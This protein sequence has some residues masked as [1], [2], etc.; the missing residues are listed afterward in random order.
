MRQE[1]LELLKQK[2][3]YF[4]NEPIYDMGGG[5]WQNYN[6]D[7]VFGG[8][9]I[10]VVDYWK[11]ETVDIVD[12]IQVLSTF[13]DNS[14][15]NIFSSDALEHVNNPWKCVKAFH[16]VLKPAGVLYI[17]VPFI[18]HQHGHINDENELVDLWRFTPMALRVLFQDYFEILEADWDS[19]RPNK[20]S[21]SLWRCGCHIIAKNLEYKR[22]VEEMT[23]GK[24]NLETGGW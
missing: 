20:P 4:L 15:G 2:N 23:M 14:I 5:N 17:T 11:S 8:R 1:T 21:D 18:W 3:N 9:E 13:K 16:R 7:E 19:S 6:L 24:P 10:K 22:N 12:D